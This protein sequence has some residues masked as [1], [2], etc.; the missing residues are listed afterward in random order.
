M[1]FDPDRLEKTGPEA[2]VL[3]GVQQD[4]FIG[5]APYAFSDDGMLVY[6]PGGDTAAGGSARR[7]PVWVDRVGREEP[8]AIEPG[9]YLHPRVSPDGQRLALSILKEGNQDVWIFDL[10]REI[11]SRLTFDPGLDGRP[12]W[13][14]DGERVVFSSTR[15][16]GG[17]FQKAFDGTGQVERLTTNPYNQRPYSF[18]PDGTQ[19]VFV[20]SGRQWDIHAL[21]LENEFTS[22]PLLQTTF[23]ERSPSISP[24]GRWIA[25]M[26]NETGRFE[27]YVRPFPNVDDGG[28][29]QISRSGGEQPRWNPQGGE[30][31]YRTSNGVM[32]ASVEA[33]PNFLAGAPRQLF[34]G[35]YAD[36]NSNYPSYDI[37][38]DGQRFLMLKDVEQTEQTSQ[39]A[40]LTQLIVVENWFE[41]LNRLAPPS[42]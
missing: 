37:S 33:G 10:S 29:W 41:E 6:V 16:G 30:L 14:L 34:S 19:L 7:S 2:L 26:S 36:F 24:D 11:L 38:P 9:D 31:F 1:P 3:A 18:S 25:Y 40:G 5:G 32:A 17:L 8:L 4:G 12:I 39:V 13:T 28:K 20:E 42:P 15:E 22:R 21:A 35:N 27:V 23:S